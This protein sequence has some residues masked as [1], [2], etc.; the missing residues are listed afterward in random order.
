MASADYRWNTGTI[1]KEEIE[2]LERYGIDR[3][4]Y[5]Y[6]VDDDEGS[7]LKGDWND[8]RKEL[9]KRANAE[10][11]TRRTF[12]ASAMAGDET[13]RKYA[14]EGFEDATDV[15]TAYDHMKGLKKE[16]VGGGGMRGAENRAS[17]TQAMV[18]KDRNQ[19][20]SSFDDKFKAMDVQEGKNEDISFGSKE[21]SFEITQ[22][23]ERVSSYLNRNGSI[24]GK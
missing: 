17:L 16:N 7:H 13:S 6:Q 1:N 19:L 4:D 20:K 22:A 8:M 2:A 10:Y 11:D 24:Y 15:V 9:A 3:K 14:E 18:D 5:G 23:K 12:E 21:P